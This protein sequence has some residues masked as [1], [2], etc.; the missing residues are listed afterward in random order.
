MKNIKRSLLIGLLVITSTVL[1]AE[2]ESTKVEYLGLFSMEEKNYVVGKGKK[3]IEIK[4]TMTSCG[5]NKGWFQPFVPAKGI[6]PVTETEMLHA[7]N[8]KDAIIVD[9][10][11]EDYFLKETIPTAV[12]IPYTEMGLR[13]KDV[14]CKED[15]NKWDC[16]KASKVYGFCNGPVCPQS[17]IAMREMIRNGFPAEKIY[18]YRGGM[19]DWD[20][21]GLTT[22]KGEF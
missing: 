14:G 9:M 22:V 10:R 19:L 8:D 2:S 13:L 12:N 15:G 5:K 21:L 3:S 4:R 1:S 17:P 16:S 6:T 11:T 18:Y 7:L 20:A